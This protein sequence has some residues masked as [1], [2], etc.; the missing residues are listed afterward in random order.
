MDRTQRHRLDNI[1]IYI[2]ITLVCVQIQVKPYISYY[3]KCRARPT[4]IH[5]HTQIIY[6]PVVWYVYAGLCREDGWASE[7][8]CDQ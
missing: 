3:C 4:H 1:Y 8:R 5:G 2:Y 6:T 7:H